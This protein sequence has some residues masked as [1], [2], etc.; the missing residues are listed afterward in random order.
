MCAIVH[1]QTNVSIVHG[2]TNVCNSTWANRRVT[3]GFIFII[4]HKFKENL[5]LQTDKLIV[6][7]FCIVFGNVINSQIVRGY[8]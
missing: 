8:K 2:Q 6:T 7:L 4:F 3:F 1:G 5:F